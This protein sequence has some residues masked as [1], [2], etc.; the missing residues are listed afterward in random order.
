[1]I[2]IIHYDGTREEVFL[3]LMDIFIKFYTKPKCPLCDKART[4]LNGLMKEYHLNVE[5]V[6]ILDNPI[7]YGRY[8][9]EIPVLLSPGVF[10]LREE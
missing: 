4:L 2:A 10:Q 7:L 5:E 8:K 1:M 3:S 9:Y 6:N